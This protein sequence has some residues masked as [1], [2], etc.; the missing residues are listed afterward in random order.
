VKNVTICADNFVPQ[1]GQVYLATG[2]V[3]IN[4]YIKL[5]N[6][7][8]VTIDLGAETISGSGTVTLIID[9]T[10]TDI[11]K[12]SFDVNAETGIITPRMFAGY[13]LKL[14]SLA[15]FSVKPDL[16]FS[17]T[18][19]ALQGIA[20]G[21][22]NLGIILPENDL[23]KE[24][25]FALDHKGV[26]S[27]T[28]SSLDLSVA[29]CA[30]SLT[31]ATLSNAGFH[32]ASATLTLPSALGGSSATVKD[33]LITPSE[34]KIGGGVVK[35]NL[36]NIKVG[37]AK[38]FKIE[39]A[40]AELALENNKY[41]FKG[42]GTLVLPNLAGRGDCAISVSFELHSMSLHQ[43]C[44]KI[45]GTCA[46][47]P[48]GQTGFFLTGIGGCVTF[49]ENSVAIDV[50][51]DIESGLTVPS[52]GAAIS[53]SPAA[54]I[55]TAGEF[56]LSGN[57]KVFSYQAANAD[58]KLNQ[59]EG[60]RGTI[61][62]SIHG[63]LDGTSKLHVWKDRSTFHFTGSGTVMVSVPKGGIYHNCAEVCL[64]LAGCA[65][66][67]L[68]VPPS[69]VNLGNVGI[70]FGEFKTDGSRVYGLKG[71]ASYMGY[72][73]AF[74][75][76][77]RGNISFGGDLSQY[78]LVEQAAGA[79]LKVLT[80]ETIPVTVGPAESVFFVLAWLQGNPTLSLIDPDG[81][82][83]TADTAAVDPN[84]FYTSTITQSLFSIVNPSP[85]VWQ[86]Q[87]G[88]IEGD[89]FY[90]FVALGANIP[91]T[92]TVIAPS[93]LGESGDHAY[94]VSWQASDPDDVPEIALYYDD[95]DVGNDGTLIAQD[96]PATQSS[97]VWDTSEVPTGE[98]YVYIVADDGKNAPVTA[99]S[100]GTVSVTNTEPPAAPVG[101]SASPDL[102]A[103]VLDW[104]P[105][106]EADIAGYKV[107]YGTASGLYNQ[108]TDVGSSVGF[109]QRGLMPGMRYYFALTAY[110]T[111]GNES[112]YSEEVSAVPLAARIYLPLIMKSFSTGT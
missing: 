43:A 53:G 50:S 70:D 1:D 26:V 57:L 78:K 46:K 12:D 37:G 21:M 77:A 4:D 83:I 61:N 80:A 6:D 5:G 64:P 41:K 11:F 74:F 90:R 24:V 33:V 2:N 110:D 23:T 71:S 84:I 75:V 38:G 60:L 8:E 62:I 15:G 47:M 13:S 101:L 94:T 18:M 44:L 54:H 10:A 56:G 96:I 82:V 42:E 35:I 105:N 97:Y 73:T 88:N 34:L 98:Y 3:R 40:S 58:L 17:L 28:L 92:V 85:G 69:K 79:G 109:M 7:G 93:N 106:S 9:S 48:I 27:G 22:L 76:D 87:I 81:R 59:R 104:T 63:V 49:N 32:V 30:L 112:E 14:S 31:D 25:S 51:V 111:S 36:P 99:Y 55:D 19:D 102:R 65:T 91:P 103:I 89:E 86:A 68:D 100:A 45:S 66:T 72:S 16:P 108:V 67:C 29:S 39:G 52:L 20:S 107:H 95:D